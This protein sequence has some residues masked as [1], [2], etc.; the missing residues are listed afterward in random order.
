MKLDMD[1]DSGLPIALQI[2][3]GIR[4][5]IVRNGAGGGSRLPSI[6]RLSSELHVSRNAA[7]EAY[8]RLVAQGL[9]RSKP[10]S[11]FYVADGAA[12]MLAGTE[13]VSEE[14]VADDRWSLF[15]S[16][17]STL[18]LG[19]GWL[20]GS[21]LEVEDLSYA[22]R[23]VT[24][25]D[26]AGIL[27]YSTPLGTPELRSL[28]RERLRLLGIDAGTQQI[29][30]TGGGSHALDLLVRLL[31]KP[32]DTVFVES[33]G[34][35]NLLGLLKLQQVQVVGVPR[36]AGGPDPE[37]MA[38]LL[39]THK[40]KLFFTNSVFQNP[41][42]TTLAPTFAHR[43]LQLAE[44]H[45][46]QIVEDDIYADFQHEPTLR[47]AALDGLRRVIYLGSFSKSLSSSLRVGFIAA[48]PARIKP[49]VDIKMLT[50]ISASRFSEQ[51]VMTMLHNG[52]YRKLVERL[53]T[54]L[55]AQMVTALNL[56]RSAGWE[57]HS[58]PAGGMFIWARYPGVADSQKLVDLAR[59]SGVSLSPGHLFLPG[60][61]ASPW[62]RLNVAYTRDRR[63]IRFLNDPLGM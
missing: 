60:E 22:I 48:A 55:S 4:H 9:V 43:I 15:Q 63:A 42:G 44:Q 13:P 27:D 40:P 36:L 41:T 46:F 12:R 5:W 28:I 19:C 53:R 49:L 14:E 34:Y 51:V 54:R 33:P 35:Y 58:E 38:H 31:L 56:V 50:S 52:A 3:D 62:L 16:D 25:Q 59:Q 39:K 17:S 57:V 37:R 1:P 18:K 26:S 20:P 47:L 2:E 10:G 45:D 6:R 8:E 24:R 21:W 23:Q 7:I 30:L 32:G 61:T 29:L 11:G